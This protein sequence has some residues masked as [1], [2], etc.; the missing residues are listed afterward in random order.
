MKKIDSSKLLEEKDEK[1]DLDGE[2]EEGFVGDEGGVMGGD[3]KTHSCPL[4]FFFSQ[5]TSTQEG[6]GLFHSPR[7]A[8][9]ILVK[10]MNLF[11]ERSEKN[12]P[13]SPAAIIWKIQTKK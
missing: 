11:K 9:L 3:A 1:R 4:F 6:C 5:P 2:V 10:R 12:R 13:G 8:Y 7:L